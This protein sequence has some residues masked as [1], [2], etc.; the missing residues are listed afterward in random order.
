MLKTVLGW[1]VFVLI[2][3]A[4]YVYL[5]SQPYDI[6]KDPEENGSCGPRSVYCGN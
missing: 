4:V 1:I 3:I 6:R 5:F 2:V